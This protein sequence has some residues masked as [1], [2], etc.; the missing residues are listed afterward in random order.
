M[1]ANFI[2]FF[3]H[4]RFLASS[5][6]RVFLPHTETLLRLDRQ[7]NKKILGGKEEEI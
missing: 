2:V 3:S 6:G 1:L 4:R 7:K 5:Q